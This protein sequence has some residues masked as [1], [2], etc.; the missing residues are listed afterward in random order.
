VAFSRGLQRDPALAMQW[1]GLLRD[2]AQREASTLPV[3][4][5]W[6]RRDMTAAIRYVEAAPELSPVQR[7]NI[8]AV[9]VA[10]GVERDPADE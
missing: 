9:L 5:R 7:Q 8:R 1:V 4:E 3:I 10:L 6:G 2:R